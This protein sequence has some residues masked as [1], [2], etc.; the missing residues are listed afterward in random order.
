M[1]RRMLFSSKS[2]KQQGVGVP[3]LFRLPKRFNLPLL[4][5]LGTISCEYRYRANTDSVRIHAA[6]ERWIAIIALY[7]R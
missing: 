4:S 3:P 1:V 5:R 6:R 2:Y 7:G